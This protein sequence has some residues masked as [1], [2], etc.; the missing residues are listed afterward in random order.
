MV[1][2][3]FSFWDGRLGGARASRLRRSASSPNAIGK[4]SQRDVANGDR[5]GRAPH[6]KFRR[7]N[8]AHG[9]AHNDGLNDSIPLELPDARANL[10][11]TPQFTIRNCHGSFPVFILGW[12]I[13]GSAGVSPAAFGVLAECDWKMFATG[14]CKRR[15][16]RSRSPFQIPQGQRGAGRTREA[17]R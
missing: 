14:R 11:R 12:M 6:S 5:D 9:S 15:P 7:G 17:G 1:L 13:G 4:C 2:F 3:R 16:G 8:G 10:S